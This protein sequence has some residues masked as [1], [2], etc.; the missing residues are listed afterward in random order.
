VQ[1]GLAAGLGIGAVMLIIFCSY[2]LAIWYG[3]KMILEKGYNG[4][5][6][7]NV[8]FAVLTGSM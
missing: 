3:G 6:V 5:E 8:V 7:M 1:E 2:A 4:G